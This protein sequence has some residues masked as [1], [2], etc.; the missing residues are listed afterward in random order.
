MTER[1]AHAD[2]DDAARE[3]GSRPG[4]VARMLERAKLEASKIPPA[5]AP[6]YTLPPP[7]ATEPQPNDLD[8]RTQV[9]EYV[10]IMERLTGLQSRLV[11]DMRRAERDEA[12]MREIVDIQRIV[13][14]KIGDLMYTENL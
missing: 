4:E 8:A 10:A 7:R 11:E 12:A 9:R 1:T 2:L 5:H 14:Q 6:T 13:V 3:L